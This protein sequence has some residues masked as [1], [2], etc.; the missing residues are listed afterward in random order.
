[1]TIADMTTATRDSNDVSGRPV[2]PRRAPRDHLKARSV[3]RGEEAAT[4]AELVRAARAD[5]DELTGPQ[6]LLKRI[7][8]MVLETALEEEMTEH[9]GRAKHQASHSAQDAVQDVD[10]GVDGADGADGEGS[11]GS[12]NVRNGTR[13]KTV[14]TD[15]VG[16]VTVEVPRDRAGTFEPQIV[17]RHQRK[18]G[19]VDEIVLSLAAKGLTC[20]EVSAHLAEIYGAT[21]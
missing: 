10:G 9:L 14:L 21:I 6:G 5:G 4:I 1:M 13:V 11:A 17:R 18:L 3:V 2:R 16:K 15:A 20:G 12:R 19:S 8:K 7:T